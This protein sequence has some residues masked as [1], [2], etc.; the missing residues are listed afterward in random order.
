MIP[1]IITLWG[2]HIA[3]LCVL[4]LILPFI[5]VGLVLQKSQI[6]SIFFFNSSS[7]LNLIKVRI[8]CS[9]VGL[10]KLKT[11][12]YVFNG[13]FVLIIRLNQQDL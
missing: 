7:C 5:I 6:N 8:D 2:L 3:N 11:N 9:M 12:Y 13:G 1:L 10:N 4:C